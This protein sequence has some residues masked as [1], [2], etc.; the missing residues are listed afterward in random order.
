MVE[1]HGGGKMEGIGVERVKDPEVVVC[2]PHTHE[3]D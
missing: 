1:K 3:G 2:L